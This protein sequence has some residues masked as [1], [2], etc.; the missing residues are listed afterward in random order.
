M[1]EYI[2]SNGRF[3]E[4]S[5]DDLMHYGVL[6]M[7]WGVRRNATRAYERASKKRAAL[8]I[9]ADKAKVKYGK[10]AGIHLTDFGV[11][12]ER[13]A[14]K[15]S[16]RAT[17]K[18]IKWQKAMEKEFSATKLISLEKKYIS[19]G[20]AYVKKFDAALD[21]KKQTAYSNK[22]SENYNKGKEVKALRERLHENNNLKT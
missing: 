13:K 2:I 21:P 10:K 4:I 8:N 5:D 6:G 16:A 18:A 1:S 17:A 19:K 22:A 12:A 11:A 20:E 15:K 3:H 14:R 9:K 7:K